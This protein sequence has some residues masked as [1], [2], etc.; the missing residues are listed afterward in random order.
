MLRLSLETDNAAFAD[1]PATECARIL[2][3]IATRLDGL[4][5]GRFY[6]GHVCDLNGNRIGKIEFDAE[7]SL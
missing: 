1:L 5:G 6:A 4:Y 3:E 2:R 7:A